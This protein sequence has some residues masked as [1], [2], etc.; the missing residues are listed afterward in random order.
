MN[1]NGRI[2]PGAWPGG[3]KT[4]PGIIAAAKAWSDD[5]D[6]RAFEHALAWLREQ[7]RA[8]NSARV[9]SGRERLG[10]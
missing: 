7:W 1:T 9:R 4:R 3:D 8:D 5:V 2:F 6:R 10:E